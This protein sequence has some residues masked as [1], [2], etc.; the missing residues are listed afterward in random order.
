MS[1]PESNGKE[2]GL[3]L[4]KLRGRGFAYRTPRPPPPCT[5]SV[6]HH[7][8]Y[9]RVTR[10]SALLLPFLLNHSF[11]YGRLTSFQP[12]KD[13]PTQRELGYTY[14][15]ERSIITSRW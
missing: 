14:T 6:P 9:V 8:L 10:L 7:L 1:Q 12:C 2:S 15:S 3:F 5:R 11:Y 4:Q 13:T